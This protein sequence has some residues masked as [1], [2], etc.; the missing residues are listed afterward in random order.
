[1]SGRATEAARLRAPHDVDAGAQFLLVDDLGSESAHAG[2]LVQTQGAGEAVAVDKEL[3]RAATASMELA[4]RVLEQ[5]ETE[6]AVAPG[7]VN[8][9][10][11]HHAAGAIERQVRAPEREAGDTAPVPRPPTTTHPG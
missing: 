3:D 4:E 10:A 1:M 8:G 5:R 11:R 9:K 7:G 6:T 2:A